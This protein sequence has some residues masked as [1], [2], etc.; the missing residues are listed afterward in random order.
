MGDAIII[1][2]SD[3]GS[4][5]DDILR[6]VVLDGPQVA[7]LPFS[8]RHVGY[9]IGGLHI[10]ALTIGLGA[11]EVNFACLQLTLSFI[12]DKNEARLLFFLRTFTVHSPNAY[13]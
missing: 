8:C 4:H 1:V 7:K 12:M 11:Y 9:D 3:E 6:I 2:A 13:S 5:G 10:D